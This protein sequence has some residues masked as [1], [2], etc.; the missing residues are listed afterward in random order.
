MIAVLTR[1]ARQALAWSFTVAPVF[2]TERIAHTAVGHE[3]A[4]L[5]NFS[6]V[7]VRSFDHLVG[8]GEQARR[9]FQTECLGGL[10]VDHQFTEFKIM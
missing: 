9:D 7:Y 6:P 1:I 8:A 10:E 3:R 5:Q 2:P 4:A